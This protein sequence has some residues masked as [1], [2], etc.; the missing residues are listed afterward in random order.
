MNKL[1]FIL[2]NLTIYCFNKV[3]VA[4]NLQWAK[5]LESAENDVVHVYHIDFDIYGNVYTVGRYYGTIDFD[6]GNGVYNLVN[7]SNLYSLF[8]LKMDANGNFLWVKELPEATTISPNNIKTDN[9]GNVY[10]SGSYWGTIDIDPGPSIAYITSQSTLDIFLLKLDPLGNFI[11]GK[12]ISG[13][14]FD[15][16]ENLA[17]D[18][19]NNIYVTGFFGGNVDFDPSTGI[20]S[21]MSVGASDYFILKLDENANFIWVK[22]LTGSISWSKGNGIAF[23]LN[24]NATFCGSFSGTTDF[25]PG[26]AT[27]NLI[28]AGSKDAFILKLDASGNFKWA[29]KL[30]GSAI[31]NAEAIAMDTFGNVFSTGK[32]ELSADF[33]P[34]PGNFNMIANDI[35]DIFISKLDTLGNF[36]W[37]KQLG[38][39][40]GSS[41][42]T[43]INLDQMGNLYVTGYFG[44]SNDFDPSSGTSN[45]N[46]MGVLSVFLLKFDLNGNFI[47]AKIF[48]TNFTV[49]SKATTIDLS[50]NIYVT[51]EFTGICDFDLSLNTFSLTSNLSNVADVYILKFDSIATSIADDLKIQRLKFYP[52]P[53]IDQI[54]FSEN[55][56]FKLINFLGEVIEERKNANSINLSAFASG[57]YLL[58][59]SDNN[60]N[61]IQQ[62]KIIKE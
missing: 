4:Q 33:N 54:H 20:S 58:I 13:P 21:L 28:S 53:T 26:S 49:I 1:F 51:G 30:G 19:D 39:D 23:D 36:V 7:T 22:Q 62:S 59:F 46:G 42:V 16:A 5:Q 6:P 10:V 17:L 48:N 44:G 41:Q 34:G 38:L 52:N 57:F 8:I 43:G 32:F 12:Q 45:L 50:G 2:L 25:D 61:F 37:A 18:H 14:D 47:W 31:D 9:L 35:T 24:G 56:N 11:F 27:M 29:S 60:G 15:V 40:S 3:A 55:T